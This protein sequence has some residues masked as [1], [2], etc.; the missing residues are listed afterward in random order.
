MDE[1]EKMAL[2]LINVIRHFKQHKHYMPKD[3]SK[4][5]LSPAQL[6][7][8]HVCLMGRNKKSTLKV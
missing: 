1:K 6:T 5:C 4:E 3:T 8:L 7:F 2:E